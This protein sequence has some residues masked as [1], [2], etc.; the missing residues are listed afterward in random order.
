V[1]E[2]SPAE[3]TT[4]PLHSIGDSIAVE[5]FAV[6]PLHSADDPTTAVESAAEHLSLLLTQ[7]LLLML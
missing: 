6:E 3:S 7:M 4:E 2:P 1:C 5:E